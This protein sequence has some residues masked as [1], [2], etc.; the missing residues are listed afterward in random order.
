MFTT[1]INLVLIRIA[2]ILRAS[3]NGGD[4][5]LTRGKSA[6]AH[7][8]SRQPR[9]VKRE[10]TKPGA[11]LFERRALQFARVMGYDQ[12]NY[13]E[14]PQSVRTAIE[15]IGYDNF[16]NVL[17]RLDLMTGKTLNQVANKYGVHRSRV[18]YQGKR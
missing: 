7:K 18:Y 4:M 9:E 16:L 2:A 1:N 12:E 11:P 6:Q 5:L 8:V 14:L 3:K 10:D 17:I 15:C 13:S